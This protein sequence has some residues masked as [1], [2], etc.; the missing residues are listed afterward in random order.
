MSSED[1]FDNATYPTAELKKRQS[2]TIVTWGRVCP[3]TLWILEQ[4]P[5]TIGYNKVHDYGR[6]EIQ[7]LQCLHILQIYYHHHRIEPCQSFH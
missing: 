4:Y 5:A 6:P 7:E 3:I 1:T 2:K